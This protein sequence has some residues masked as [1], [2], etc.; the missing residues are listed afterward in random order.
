LFARAVDTTPQQLVAGVDE[1]LLA[2]VL[3][4]QL[5]DL[6]EEDLATAR[7]Q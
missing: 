4:L 2:H 1:A 3:A 5:W 7:R 6:A